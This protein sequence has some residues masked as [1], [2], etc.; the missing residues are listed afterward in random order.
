MKRGII[1]LVEEDPAAQLSVFDHNI[2]PFHLIQ[3]HLSSAQKQ[4]LK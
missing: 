2:S 4:S 3:G 1:S